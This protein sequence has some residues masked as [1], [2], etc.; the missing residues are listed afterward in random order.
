[1]QY[2]STQLINE[3]SQ[4]FTFNKR[5]ITI[6]GDVGIGTWGK[7]DYLKKCGYRIVREVK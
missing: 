6:S 5:T 1:M 4:R 3:L 2:N 7:L